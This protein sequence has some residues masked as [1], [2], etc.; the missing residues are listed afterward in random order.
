MRSRNISVILATSIVVFIGCGSSSPDE[1]FTSKVPKTGQIVSYVD[2]DDG[3]Y[4]AQGL[5]VE[6]IFRREGDIVIDEVTGLEWDDDASVAGNHRI[7][8]EVEDKCGGSWRLPTLVELVSIADKGTHSPSIFDAFEN[9][10]LPDATGQRLYWT[11]DIAWSSDRAWAVSFETG[12][13]VANNKSSD[14]ADLR[15]V[16]GGEIPSDSRFDFTKSGVVTDTWTNLMWQKDYL[17][18]TTWKDAIDQCEALVLNGKNDWR[19]PNFHEFSA[20]S[21]D[22]HMGE[23]LTILREKSSRIGYRA[24]WTSTTDAKDNLKAWTFLAVS[25][26]SPRYDKSDD[27]PSVKCVRTR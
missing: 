12:K 22:V 20:I 14:T 10:S 18:S 16:R 15:C 9:V 4:A 1:V 17:P 5:G 25:G 8:T 24:Y 3:Y 21:E 23:P 11:Q 27:Y 19:L 26:A 6:R 13:L 2:F 7:Y